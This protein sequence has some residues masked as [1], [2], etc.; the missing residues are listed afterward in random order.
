[1]APEKANQ[2]ACGDEVGRVSLRTGHLRQQAGSAEAGCFVRPGWS[3]GPM[4][5]VPCPHLCLTSDS[6]DLWIP[7]AQIPTSSKF[8]TGGF[9]TLFTSFLETLTG[10]SKVPF[11]WRSPEDVTYRFYTRSS[12]LHNLWQ[13]ETRALEVGRSILLKK[14]L[15]CQEPILKAPDGMGE[16][17]SGAYKYI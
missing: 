16:A 15:A 4:S 17:L 8:R 7:P 6:F 13:E 10:N 14:A 11:S 2:A 3:L 5:S 9:G 1:M 12:L